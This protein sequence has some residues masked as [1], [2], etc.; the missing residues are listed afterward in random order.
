MNPTVIAAGAVVWRYDGEGNVHVLLIHRPRYDDWSIP[1]GKLD[2]GEQLIACAYR[3]VIEETHLKVSFGPFITETEYYVADGLKRVS[4]WA[5]HAY[6]PNDNFVANAEADE[7]RWLT[8]EEAIEL[9]TRE[10]DKEVLSVFFKSPFDSQALIM[11]RHG[12]ALARE[13][14][15]GGDEDRPLDQRGSLQAKRMISIYQAFNIEKVITSDAIRC[16]DTVEPLTKALDLKLKVEKDISEQSWKKD[17]ELAIEFA[18]EIIKDERTILVCSHNPVLP[19]MLEKLTK[20]IDF[21]YPDNKLQPGEA[22]IIHHKKKEVLQIDRL[23][24]PTT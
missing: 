15:L 11:L 18:K 2:E 1:K 24:A 19:R 4:Y 23:E 16:Y 17:K 21:D 20:K 8:I 3:E 6:D 10:S 12:K 13:E 14:W 9:A 7:G 22:W 5:A